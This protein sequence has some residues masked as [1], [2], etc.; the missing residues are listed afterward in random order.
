MEIGSLKEQHLSEIESFCNVNTI[1][2]KSLGS[3]TVR[4][5]TFLYIFSKDALS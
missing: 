3:A 1:P 2:F 5:K 4:K